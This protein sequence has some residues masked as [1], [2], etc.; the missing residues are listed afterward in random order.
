MTDSTH[1]SADASSS[2]EV[3]RLSR[4]RRPSAT[5]LAARMRAVIA[6]GGSIPAPQPDHPANDPEADLFGDGRPATTPHEPYANLAVRVRRSLD[7]R[8]DDLAID[9]RRQGVRSSRA[10]IIEL[11]LWE[12]PPA[13]DASFRARL[14]QFREHAPREVQP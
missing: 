6:K 8:L 10:E 12:L 2:A 5:E 1:A 3:K 13:P 9:L 4:R 11:L 7:A 14:A